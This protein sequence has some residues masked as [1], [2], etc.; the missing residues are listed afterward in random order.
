MEVRHLSLTFQRKQ[1]ESRRGALLS[2]LG[3]V[4]LLNSFKLIDQFNVRKLAVE[5][6]WVDYQ[7]LAASGHQSLQQSANSLNPYDA[8]SQWA[9]ASVN[10]V[11]EYDTM[12]NQDV[13][14][15]CITT[16]FMC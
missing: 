15:G 14:H 8:L 6:H 4:T 3:A 10:F 16:R 13:V 5:L 11:V 1:V 12:I 7:P 9:E 2:W